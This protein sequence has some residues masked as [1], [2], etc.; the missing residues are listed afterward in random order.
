MI[1]P[2]LPLP[3][4]SSG[5]DSCESCK[6]LCEKSKD[7]VEKLESKVGKMTI[8]LTVSVTL[9]GQELAKTVMS[10]IDSINK[11]S[12]V[13]TDG[14]TSQTEDKGEQS[15]KFELKPKSPFVLPP[16]DNSDKSDKTPMAANEPKGDS[17]FKPSPFTNSQSRGQS[18]SDIQSLPSAEDMRN[19]MQSAL[20]EPQELPN[21]SQLMSYDLAPFGGYD[22]YTVPALDYTNIPSPSGIYLFAMGGMFGSRNRS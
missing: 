2:S 4:N 13:S 15:N 1:K 7:K 14:G 16:S 19:L 20:N 21:L 11:M 5:G 9:L 6:M 17:P 12:D 22:M 3:T 8:A 18:N 10:Y